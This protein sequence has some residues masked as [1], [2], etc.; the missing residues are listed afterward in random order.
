[1]CYYS[2][3]RGRYTQRANLTED[4]YRYP[5]PPALSEPELSLNPAIAVR[6]GGKENRY[7]YSNTHDTYSHINRTVVY[8]KLTLAGWIKVTT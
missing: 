5:A 1:M 6:G 8:K 7:F 2:A 3:R 4:Q